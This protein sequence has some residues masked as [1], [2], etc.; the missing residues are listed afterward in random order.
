MENAEMLEASI[1]PTSL[2]EPSFFSNMVD[3][4]RRGVDPDARILVEAAMEATNLALNTN[5]DDLE[6]MMRIV[7]DTAMETFDDERT[8]T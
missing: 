3:V 4:F 8:K 7:R 6:V 5:G 1:T 2:E